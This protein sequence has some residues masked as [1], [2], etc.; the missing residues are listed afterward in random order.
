N[1][2]VTAGS[3]DHARLTRA[4][5]EVLGEIARLV[6]LDGE[7]ST[8]VVEIVVRGARFV[9]DACRVARAIGDS[10]LCKAAFHG[11]DPN[12][13]RFV[14]AAGNAGVPID[15]ERVD[16]TIGGVAVARRGRPV[17][18]ALGRARARMLGRGLAI[19][20]AGLGVGLVV[21][22]LFGGVAPALRFPPGK[23]LRKA[24]L[25]AGAAVALAVGEEALFRGIVL[26]RIRRDAGDLLAVAATALLY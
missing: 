14:M 2:P 15:Q 20:L 17:A 23:T 12:W 25:G 11:G 7:G 3:R 5:R 24:L 10:T 19:G 13:G 26:R 16:V 21:A 18:G 1:R 9:R 6:V 4:V 22:A 8:R